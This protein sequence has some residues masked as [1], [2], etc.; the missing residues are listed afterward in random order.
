M[1]SGK[2]AYEGKQKIN[3]STS[4]QQVLPGIYQKKKQNKTNE[5]RVT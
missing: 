5:S 4:I 2:S 1:I 3:L